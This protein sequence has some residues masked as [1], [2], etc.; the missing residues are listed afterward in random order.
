MG[1]SSNVRFQMKMRRK[2]MI[3]KV[4]LSMR[5]KRRKKSMRWTQDIS[6]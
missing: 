6:K 3:R 1:Y 2:K 4:N 5:L